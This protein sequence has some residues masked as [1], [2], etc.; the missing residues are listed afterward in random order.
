MKRI[1]ASI[2]TTGALLAMASPALA[3]SAHPIGT[4]N[5]RSG[6]GLTYAVLG[7]LSEGE[8]ASIVGHEGEWLKVRTAGG[9]TGYM[10]DWVTLTVFDDEVSYVQVTT[11]VLNVRRGPSEHDDVV[12]QVVQGQRFRAME[13]LGAWMK[14]DRG[15]QGHGWVWAEYLMPV[16]GAPA[17]QPAPF[18]PPVHQGGEGARQGQIKDVYA[19]V[20]TAMRNGRDL[21]YDVAARVIAGE[22]LTYL[23]SAE[24]WVKVANRA[25]DKGWVDGTELYLVDR[26]V[27]FASQALYGVKERDWRINHLRVREVVSAGA[28]LRLRSGPSADSP[29]LAGLDPGNLMKLVEVPET[30]YVKVMIADGTVGWLSRNWIKPVTGTP[31]ESARLVRTAPGVLRL[32]ITGQTAAS[33]VTVAGT[34]LQVGLTE[35]AGRQAGLQV[36]QHE[37]AAMLMDRTGFT[38][39]F[40]QPFHHT[41]VEQSSSRTV[42][43]VRPL[44]R[45]VLP[46][47]GANGMTYRFSAVGTTEPAVRREGGTVVLDLPGAAAA[48][49]LPASVGGLALSAHKGGVTGRIV[50][51]RPFAMKRGAGFVEL[52]VYSY[53]IAGKTIVVDPGHGGVETGA[54]GPTGL[55]EKDAN[56]AISLKL[57]KLLEDAGAKV[58]L[59]R[60]AD[61][62]C[63]SP[64]ELSRVPADEQLRHDLLCRS[65]VSNTAGADLFVSVHGNAHPDRSQRG[66]ETFWTGDNFNA[67]QSQR[68]AT[69]IQRE[70]VAGLGLPDR[71]VKEEIFAVVKNTDAPAAL[72]EIAFVGH[73]G[74]EALLK[75]ASFQQKAAEA[76]ARAIAEYFR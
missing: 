31:S 68:L 59:T 22:K 18:E 6:P 36:G 44:V 64:A 43:E 35:N 69:L 74:E 8:R 37:V 34:N 38:L 1:V 27:P 73:Y 14:I 76:M 56:L 17:T 19:A 42:I 28:G 51:D 45:D 15:A 29:V 53:G 55:R 39:R 25:G 7:T 75:Q 30:E 2:L 26:N 58:V 33:T 32:E 71:G 41:V 40:D 70:L 12:G 9:L 21:R 54:V 65:I 46:T 66:T 11:D 50:T 61:T 16:K 4:V 13:Q 3:H 20:S 48:P 23:D 10:A 62:R 63:A 49:G 47:Q 60:T 24:G 52:V 5:I 72:A 67:P 57:A